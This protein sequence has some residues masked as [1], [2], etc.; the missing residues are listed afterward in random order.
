MSRL[1]GIQSLKAR[2]RR[3]LVYDRPTLRLHY[4]SPKSVMLLLLLGVGMLTA[5]LG[6]FMGSGG[7][8]LLVPLLLFIFPSES[9]GV[10]SGM[11]LATVAI[12]SLSASVA[13]GRQRRIRYSWGSLLALGSVPGL[14][15][16]SVIPLAMG[17]GFFAGVTG[18]GGGLLF[19]PMIVYLY[20]LAPHIATATSQFAIVIT[21]SSA[22][23]VRA[24]LL[25]FNSIALPT[26]ALII[27]AVLGG[28]IGPVLSR[29][30]SGLRIMR[31]LAVTL[32]I[33]GLRL[34]ASLL[35]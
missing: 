19:V 22:L 33:A 14:R 34:A 5:A 31:V 28:Q 30:F 1:A 7:G 10:I 8:F 21:A 24:T 12:T 29:R 2:D 35:S 20:G 18:I 6:T 9:P 16:I 11:S 23:A 27:G 32:G 26:L 3:G 25:D 13:Y 15:H 4:L 17:E